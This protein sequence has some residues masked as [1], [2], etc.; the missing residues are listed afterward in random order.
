MTT[1]ATPTH[2]TGPDEESRRFYRRMIDVLGEADVPFLVGGS[3]A[4]ACYT[5]IERHSKDFDIFVRPEE[6][7]RA[8]VALAGAGCSIIDFSPHWLSK[9][10]AGEDFIDIIVS[11]G[12]GIAQV[13]EAWFERAA[14]GEALGRP[15]RLVPAEELLW[16]KAF[17]LERERFDGADIAHLVHDYGDRL[18]WRHLLDRFGAHWRVL[19]VH[20]V[21]YGFIYPSRRGRV[22]AWV[23]E[24]LAD[25]LAREVADPE[26][27]AD[28]HACLGTL[29][30][31]SQYLV[32]V[33]ER[34][35]RDGR[36]P[37]DG[38]MTAH[39]IAHWTARARLDGA[40]TTD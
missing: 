18:D 33:E 9:A 4:L 2:A 5:G 39:D 3:F 24:E 7:D 16:S 12:N 10:Q 30:S 38:T 26:G 34:G 35:Y 28:H 27:D 20:L 6:R 11:S 15:V 17:I 31:R 22:P 29:L 32:D 19:Y 21:L 40:V 36:L 23:M 8:H 37:P 1:T 25:R 13:D 14:D